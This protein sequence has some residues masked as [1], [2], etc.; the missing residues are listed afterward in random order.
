VTL[1]NSVHDAGSIP[2]GSINDPRSRVTPI[3]TIARASSIRRSG[4]VAGIEASGT[5][6]T[7]AVALSLAGFV[8]ELEVETLAVLE[9]SLGVVGSVTTSEIV[10][11]PPLTIVASEQM[12]V[13]VPT[14]LPD[15]ASQR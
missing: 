6:V 5:T 14:Q 11:E 8:S 9:R 13:D 12:T 2:V 1:E 3:V 7:V 4:D 10:A 15:L